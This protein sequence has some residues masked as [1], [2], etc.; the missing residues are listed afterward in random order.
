MKLYLV[1]CTAASRAAFLVYDASGTRCC[2]VRSLSGLLSD[3]FQILGTFAEQDTVVYGTQTRLPHGRR[4][5]IEE[6]GQKRARVFLL[7]DDT[8]SSIQVD[9]AVCPVLGQ[10]L[11]GEYSVLAPNGDPIYCQRHFPQCRN[12]SV[13]ELDIMREELAA[14]CVGIAV[15]LNHKPTVYRKTFVPVPAD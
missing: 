14:V 11:R 5:V 9:R 1:R 2:T 4:F 6:N 3:G 10:P 7:P 12:A 8:L 13:Y 15:C